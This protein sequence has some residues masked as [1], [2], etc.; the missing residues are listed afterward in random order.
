M[1]LAKLW[2]PLNHWELYLLLPLNHTLRKQLSQKTSYTAFGCAFGPN[3][4]SSQHF[5]T[6]TSSILPHLSMCS[7]W[8]RLDQAASGYIPQTILTFSLRIHITAYACLRYILVDPL[9][10]RYTVTPSCSENASDAYKYESSESFHP[11]SLGTFHL[12]ITVLVLFRSYI[13]FR[14]RKWSSFLLSSHTV[15]RYTYPCRFVV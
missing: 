15:T 2:A 14:L 11:H 13:L 10:K 7:I 1:T 8:S 6:Y 5:A 3:R 9:Y 4:N 12:S